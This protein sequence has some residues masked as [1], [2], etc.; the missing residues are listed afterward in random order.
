MAELRADRADRGIDLLQL[1][2]EFGEPELGGGAR[3]PELEDLGH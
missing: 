1:C 3:P 2:D